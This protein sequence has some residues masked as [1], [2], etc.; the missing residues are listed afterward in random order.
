VASAPKRPSLKEFHDL[1]L[2]EKRGYK[3][4]FRNAI[5]S[6]LFDLGMVNPKTKNP[7]YSAY[8]INNLDEYYFCFDSAEFVCR[9]IEN[10]V[11][12]S[13]PNRF[14]KFPLHESQRKFFANVFGWKRIDTGNRRFME[15]F[16]YVPRKNSKTFDIACL[17]HVGML[18]DGEGA[19][20]I[21]SVAKNKQQAKL[22]QD[23][24]V[25]SI[26]NDK[27][28]PHLCANGWL[29][30]IYDIHGL[31]DVKAVT[32]DNQTNVYKALASDEGGAHGLNCHFALND[33]IHTW[34]SPD[35]FDVL[36]TS[37]GARSQPLIVSIT[38][39]D[40][41]RESF[42]NKKLNYAK[43]VCKDPNF[44]DQFLPVLYYADPEEFGDDWT[45]EKIWQ[46]VNPMLGTG[47]QWHIMRREFKQAQNESIY[48]NAFKRLHLNICT[49]AESSAYDMVCW[50][51]C[52]DLPDDQ[53]KLLGQP[54]PSFLRDAECYGGFDA[55]Y[56]WDLSAFSLDFPDYKYT[57][58]FN[59]LHSKHKEIVKYKKDFG[60]WL[61]IAGQDEIDFKKVSEGM[62]QI[63][64]AFNILDVGFDPNQSRELINILEDDKK[65]DWRC[66]K[67]AQTARNLS[68]PIKHTI[69]SVEAGNVAHNGNPL[70]AWQ[71]SNADIKEDSHNNYMFVKPKGIDAR[72]KK[73]DSAVAFAMA[74][75]RR[76]EADAGDPNHHVDRYLETGK[77]FD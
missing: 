69:S 8:K 20:E 13:K 47:K 30:R 55:A 52:V 9:W 76:L 25:G 7:M 29:G 77:F 16:R 41:A 49:K 39:A 58:T 71:L 15:A 12:H 67:I 65:H 31:K 2:W 73:I 75:A 3:T 36:Q 4:K 26:K 63:Y 74:R 10:C 50:N 23:A 62:N 54:I 66:F 70:Y 17:V 68:E 37:M 64:E 32:A 51:K 14:A 18:L 38:T 44:D 40:Y 45:D 35:M 46:R 19:P 48:E 21:Y 60:K 57:L 42:C 22:I 72:I 56:K 28:Q 34:A 61:L 53:F 24:F 1:R 59:W 11:T 6:G 43:E 27:E 33:E 5:K